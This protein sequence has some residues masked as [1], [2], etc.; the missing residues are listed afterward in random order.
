MGVIKATLPD[1]VLVSFYTALNEDGF[2]EALGQKI[3]GTGMMF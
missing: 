2:W 1:Q 3:Y